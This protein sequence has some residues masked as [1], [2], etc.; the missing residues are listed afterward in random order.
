MRF[1]CLVNQ[2]ISNPIPFFYPFYFVNQI[3]ASYQR[4]LAYGVISKIQYGIAFA[5]LRHS[6]I[7]QKIYTQHLSNNG[8]TRSVAS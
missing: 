3:R 5:L 1:R 2:S 4:D 6:M 8:N 7:G